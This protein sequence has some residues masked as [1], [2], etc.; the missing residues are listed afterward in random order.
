MALR[1]KIVKLV[2]LVGGVSGVMNKIDENAPEY[3]SLASIL[4]DDQ[5]DVAIAAGLRKERTAEYLAKKCGKPVE[6]TR[7]LALEL[8]DIG[9]F[10]VTKDSSGVDKFYMQ[11]FAPGIM[12]MLVNNPK[13]L[14]EHPEVGK[15]FEEYTRIRMATMAPMLP[16]GSGLMRVVPICYSSVALSLPSSVEKP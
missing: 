5:A 9:V 15:A 4:T 11:I 10:R 14:A 16:M 1:P 3:Y 13:Q 6:Q 2:K 12:E 7:K 8:A